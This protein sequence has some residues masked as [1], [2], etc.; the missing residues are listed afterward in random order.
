MHH[1]TAQSLKFTL[2]VCPALSPS[3]SCCIP[4]APQ[5]QHSETFHH[6]RPGGLAHS[7]RWG[8]QR[9]RPMQLQALPSPGSSTGQRCEGC[10]TLG[11]EGG[12][13]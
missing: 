12:S 13:C 2:S 10:S 8:C 3:I 4:R 1:L 5:N 7:S 11:E 9:M 6:L